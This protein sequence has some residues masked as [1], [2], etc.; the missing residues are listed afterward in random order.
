MPPSLNAILCGLLGAVAS[1]IAYVQSNMFL[2]GDAIRRGRHPL[3]D[4]L[5]F[6]GMGLILG[7]IIGIVISRVFAASPAKV[8]AL[9]RGTAGGRRSDHHDRERAAHEGG[10]GSSAVIPPRR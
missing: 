8:P 10:A 4:P 1:H 7:V 2:E 5:A 9:T 3:W 6:D